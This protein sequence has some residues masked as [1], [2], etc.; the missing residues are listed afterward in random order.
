M[1]KIIVI[2]LII[3]II[4][5]VNISE[6][7]DINLETMPS[8]EDTIGFI[9][10]LQKKAEVTNFYQPS[11]V[12][13][14]IISKTG[15]VEYIL[16]ELNPLKDAI[17][18]FYVALDVEYTEEAVD[19]FIQ[20]VNFT[21]DVSY[22]VALLLFAYSDLITAINRI[23]QIDEIFLLTGYIRKVSNILLEH[24]LE[25]DKSDI[26][27]IICFGGNIENNYEER[28]SFIIDFGGND[29]YQERNNSFIL[30]LKGGDTH[31]KQLADD[32][33]A[34]IFDLD[35]NDKYFD[36]PISYNG[37][38]IVY[39]LMGNDEYFG[40][41]ASAYNTGISVLLDSD[42]NDIYMGG[43]YTQSYSNEGTSILVDI[44]GYDIYNASSYSQACS[45]EGIAI[46]VD[47]LGNDAFFA[48]DNSQAYANGRSKR[49]MSILANL[50]GDDIYK[51]KDFSQGFGEK[52]GFAILLDILGEDVYNAQQFSQA[53]SSFGMA[54]LLDADG[55]NKFT[56]SLFS[57]GYSILTGTA[58]FLNNFNFE[59]SSEILEIINELNLSLEELFLYFF[60][61]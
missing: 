31:K 21:D 16:G 17:I 23:Q 2:V 38:N 35:G 36:S 28:Y 55:I 53:S 45:E 40:N 49:S 39:D 34:M 9:N 47:I 26:Y 60:H 11:N 29:T 13:E 58:F 27:N 19:N 44:V 4:F 12:A 37:I 15:N 52:F 6:E 59:N 25:S 48:V 18:E 14:E 43:N 41:V 3:I 20:T 33:V 24:Q 32:G 50:Q 5:Q 56:N 10:A 7:T 8:K 54:T 51:A 46:L 61:S 42:G 57:Q 1:K 22:A 30:D